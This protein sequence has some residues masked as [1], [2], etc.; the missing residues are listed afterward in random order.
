MLSLGAADALN[1]DG[2]GSSA[3]SHWD[4]AEK[5][6]VVRFRQEEPPRPCALNIGIYRRSAKEFEVKNR[7]TTSVK[8]KGK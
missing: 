8:G 5:R 3:L 2:G 7:I 1:F 6:Q 4:A